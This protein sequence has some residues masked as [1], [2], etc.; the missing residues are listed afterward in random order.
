MPGFSKNEQ[1]PLLEDRT[2]SD[3]KLKPV[4]T[5]HSEIPRALKN[6]NKP[7]LPMLYI[8]NNK[9]WMRAY[10]FTER[11]T[12]YIKPTAYLTPISQKSKK[13]SF[14]NMTVH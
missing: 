11:F 8:W 4:F 13:D 14:Q 2:T 3:R 6:Y 1:I 5:I 12:A 9:A 7:T 10:L